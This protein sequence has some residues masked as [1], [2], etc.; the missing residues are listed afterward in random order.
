MSVPGKTKAA[1]AAAAVAAALIFSWAGFFFFRDNLTTHYPLKVISAKAFRAGE[2]PWWNFHDMGG[3]PLAGNPNALTFYPDNIFYLL[4]PP[5]VAFNLHFVL[6]LLGGFVAMR[7][8]CRA[9]GLQPAD[10][11]LGGALWIL[12]GVVISVTA[13][14]NLVTSV[15]LIPLALLGV[16]RR[17]ARILG[18]AFGLMLLGSEPMTIAGTAFAA[19]IAAAGR[20]PAK[21]IAVAV[22]AALAIGSPQLIAY[23]EIAGE[24]ERSVAMSPDAV[25]AT[26]LTWQ[27][28]GEVFLWPLSGFLNDAGGLRQRLF[29]TL[30][31]GIVA[32]PAL[33]TR[34]RYV[35]I[36]L[37]C[38]FLALGSHNAVVNAMVH[39]LPAWARIM[40]YPEKLALPMTAALAVLIAG[41]LGRTRFRRA[42][43]VATF[44][45]LLW[46]AW[47]ALPVDWFAPY[48]VSPR[49]PVRVHWQ[50][51]IHPGRTDARTEYHERAEALDYMFGAAAGLR[52][53]VGRSPDNMHALLSRAVAE[54]FTNVGPALQARYLRINGC[55]VPGALPMAMIVPA[56][57]PAR[58]LVEAVRNLESHRFDERVFAVA[59]MSIAGFRSSAGRIERYVE[60]GQSVRVDVD[61]AGPLLV[62][63][64]QTF[65][66]GWVARSGELE[67]DTVPL[68]VDRLGVI[69]PAGRHEVILTFGRHRVAVIAA[70]LLSIVL[71]LGSAF[72][73]LVE[74]LHRRAGEVERPADEDRAMV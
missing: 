57:A 8:L 47:R 46:V 55:D 63:V 49:P 9:R 12:S 32:V 71:L 69:V 40:R 56:V 36:A 17:S 5:H 1:F 34:S 27:R 72:P 38:L 42:W 41:Y 20:M 24:V 13:F 62:M 6:H 30:F 35:G 52:Y 64:N 33:V 58:S 21:R 28:A 19:A 3:Q 54:R 4:F 25:L 48:R 53:G 68:N 37:G 44:V 43:L 26:S 2:I 70:W 59:P 10:A 65:F 14:Y 51:T 45:P 67:L 15:L 60:D 61:A 22:A 23:A 50:A 66:E 16:E 29:S 11:A 73:D 39:A 31:V 74:K 7:G 18:C